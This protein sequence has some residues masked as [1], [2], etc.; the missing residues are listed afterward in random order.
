MDT[1]DD[2]TKNKYYVTLRRIFRQKVNA[3]LSLP[4]P[5]KQRKKNMLKLRKKGRNSED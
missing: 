5:L 1:G 4:I 2:R 3:T